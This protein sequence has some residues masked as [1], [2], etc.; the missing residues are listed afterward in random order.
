M[1]KIEVLILD[2]ERYT[3]KAVE[4]YLDI[5]GVYDFYKGDNLSYSASFGFR[6]L[7]MDMEMEND[8]G[9][10][11]EKDIYSGPYISI[12]AKFSSAEKW[13]HIRKKDRE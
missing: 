12:R 13:T 3:I 10:A 7:F 1:T 4:I 5:K 6:N 11:K 2:N 9:W 8:M